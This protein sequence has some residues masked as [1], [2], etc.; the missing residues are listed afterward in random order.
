MTIGKRSKSNVARNRQRVFERDHETCVVAGTLWD[1]LERCRGQL[2]VQ[3]RVGRGMGGSARYDAPEYLIAMCA[4][5][6]GLQTSSALFAEA[7]ERNGWSVRRSVA[8]LYSVTGIPVFTQ[9]G[10]YLLGQDF[11]RTLIADGE[12]QGFMLMIYG[13]TD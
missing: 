3:H 8:D 10:W 12:A 5:H 11:S 13:D 2:T 7:C 9:D 4:H 1:G 6:N